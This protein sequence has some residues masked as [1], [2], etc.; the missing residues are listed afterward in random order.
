MLPRGI[1][2]AIELH[3]KDATPAHLMGVIRLLKRL[4]IKEELLKCCFNF[5]WS[6]P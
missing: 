3:P 2:K 6:H 5:P 1:E 4:G